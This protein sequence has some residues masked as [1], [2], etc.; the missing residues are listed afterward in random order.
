[1]ETFTDNVICD[2][3][4]ML[5][6]QHEGIYSGVP[7]KI[8]EMLSLYEFGDG[9]FRQKCLN[10]IRQ[11]MF[12][13]DYEDSA[14]WYGDLRSFFPV[15]HDLN[16]R[17]LRGYFAWRTKIRKGCFSR[18]CEAFVYIYVYELLNGIGTDSAEESFDELDRFYRGYV[19][20]GMGDPLIKK[21]LRRWIREFAIINDLPE[22]AAAGYSDPGQGERDHAI[23]VLLD[24]EGNSDE[25]VFS[26][27]TRFSSPRLLSSPV[28]SKDK[29]LGAHLFAEV[30]RNLPGDVFSSCFGPV[31]AY[32]WHPLA[33]AVYRE[34]RN[35]ES[36]DY[37]ISA[38]RK[39]T[40]RSGAWKEFTYDRL[41]A[42]QNAFLS[43]MHTADLKLR[44]M[45]KTGHYLRKKEGEE[46]AGELVDSALE[47]MRKEEA[48]AARPR[49]TIDFSGLDKIRDDAAATCESLLTDEER[50][51]DYMN[52]IFSVL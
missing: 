11:G 14:S 23:T 29:K 17:Q 19:V 47:K 48:E 10:F 37:E 9:S 42:D 30:W 38:C 4:S 22:G 24:P 46:W 45:L 6:T 5:G 34:K 16:I 51:G 2:R 3:G 18:T 33:G 31:K 36:L 1:M 13:K 28:I 12:M 7:V 40:C 8:R 21:N 52:D 43:L 44:R 27:L 49:I 41:S 35:I 25:D 20:T 39:Y 15:Y 26:A 32:A 50:G